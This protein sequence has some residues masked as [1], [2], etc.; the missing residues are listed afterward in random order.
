MKINYDKS[1]R[2]ASEITYMRTRHPQKSA[3]C[4]YE[5]L[6]ESPFNHQEENN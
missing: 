5:F 4:L 6:T 2:I 3:N 1:Q